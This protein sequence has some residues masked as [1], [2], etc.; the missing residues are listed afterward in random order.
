MVIIIYCNICSIQIGKKP[1]VIKGKKCVLTDRKWKD[2]LPEKLNKSSSI[3]ILL[4]TN[5]GENFKGFSTELYTCIMQSAGMCCI[6]D[7]CRICFC[8]KGNNSSCSS[9]ASYVLLYLKLNVNTCTGMEIFF[10]S[11]AVSE[12]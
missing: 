9:S 4:L 7:R 11:N 2:T 8:M 1:K 12:K 5:D 3:F 10:P 6:L